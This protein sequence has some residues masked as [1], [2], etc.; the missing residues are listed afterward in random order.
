MHG[1]SPHGSF[2]L[3]FSL[4][5]FKSIDLNILNGIRKAMFSR[6]LKFGDRKW[7]NMITGLSKP[8]ALRPGA[9]VFSSRATKIYH[10]PARRLP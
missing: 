7:P 6:G 2:G 9:I 1:K 3:K 10:C 8:L 4:I 5:Q